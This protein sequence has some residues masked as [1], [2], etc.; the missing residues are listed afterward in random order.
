VLDGLPPEAGLAGELVLDRAEGRVVGFLLPGAA[1][2]LVTPGVA[3]VLGPVAPPTGPDVPAA[4][5]ALCE[6][7][8]PAVG[9]PLVGAPAGD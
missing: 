8:R 9:A 2:W 7:T 4:P 6:G 5:E 1:C 3:A